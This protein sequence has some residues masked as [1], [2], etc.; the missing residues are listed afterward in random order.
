VTAEL[1]Q[2]ANQDET[3][4]EGRASSNNPVING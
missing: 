1:L 3:G 2:K 4:A